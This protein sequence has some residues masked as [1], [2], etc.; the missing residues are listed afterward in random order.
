L[1]NTYTMLIR[2]NDTRVGKAIVLGLL[3]GKL[4]GLLNIGVVI[5]AF[6]FILEITVLNKLVG[7]EV[8]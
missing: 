2:N 8:K 5:L 7:D 3:V 1:C 4:R 6:L